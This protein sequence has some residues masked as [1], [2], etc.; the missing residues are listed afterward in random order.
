[1]FGYLTRHDRERLG[2]SVALIFHVSTTQNGRWL[3][4][5]GCG[6]APPRL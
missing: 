4:I 5:D 1:M 3:K 6:G 2:L